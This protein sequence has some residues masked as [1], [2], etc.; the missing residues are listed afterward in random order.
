MNAGDRGDPPLGAMESE[1]GVE[2]DRTDGVAVGE[3]EVLCID[4]ALYELQPA[5]GAAVGAGFGAGHLP[6]LLADLVVEAHLRRV[7]LH[8]DREIAPHL[9]VAQEILLDDPALVAQAD[10]EI[11]DAVVGVE[12]QD[13][14]ENGLAP[15]LDHRLGL[16]VGLFADARAEPPGKDDSFHTTSRK[17]L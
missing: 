6:V 4:V 8:R 2:I 3:A 13:V 7:A 15:D 12:L 5:A 10:H 16:Q 11:V 14:P 9:V 17:C 1:Q